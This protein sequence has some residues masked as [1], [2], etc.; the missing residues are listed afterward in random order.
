MNILVI[1]FSALGDLVTLEPM[2]R[3]IRYFY[4]NAKID[5]ITSGLGKG[6]FCDTNY[7]DEYIVHKSFISSVQSLRS[8][9][10]DLVFNLHCNSL[11]HLLIL[12]CSK[13][14]VIN[15]A[16][17]L[18]Q[19]LRGKKV[20][21]KPIIETLLKTTID[22][23]KIEKYFNDDNAQIV[24]LPVHNAIKVNSTNQKIVA[25]STGSSNPWPS[26]QWGVNK[27][28]DLI[29][30]LLDDDVCVVLIGTDLE[31]EDETILRERFPMI[32]SFVAKTNLTQLKDIL[33]QADMYIGND[34]GPSHIAAA[35]QTN[36][37]TIFGPTSTV[38]CVKYAP[39]HG[40]HVCIKPSEK[41]ACHPCYKGVCP[42]KLECMED[43]KVDYVYMS[44]KEL[45]DA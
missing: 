4:P 21:V 5:F 31:I 45:I 19:K 14:K 44:V 26:K 41:I 13:T 24:T 16:A 36:T 10:Y 23:Q 17:T 1:R 30:K 35:V 34:S 9:H 12:L 6:L 2:F 27:Y 22:K 15:S 11:S 20:P 8:K 25:L 39:Y 42:T 37:V 40:K 32:Q 38:H 33:S 43:I 7:F 3:A 29:Q 28:A 18:W